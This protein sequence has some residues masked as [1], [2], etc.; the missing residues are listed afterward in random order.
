MWLTFRSALPLALSLLS[1]STGFIGR[2]GVPSLSLADP[3]I[4]RCLER[5]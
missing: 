1:I 3:P 5:A 4:Q 2:T